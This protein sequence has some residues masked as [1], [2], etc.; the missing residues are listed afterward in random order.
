MKGHVFTVAGSSFPIDNNY[1]RLGDYLEDV[2]RA[3]GF[4]VPSEQEMAP[5]FYPYH[6]VHYI[7]VYEK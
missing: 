1:A 4:W 5:R 6:A 7:V 2:K 3:G